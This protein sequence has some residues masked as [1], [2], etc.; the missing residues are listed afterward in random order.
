MTAGKIFCS[1]RQKIVDKRA[2]GC[3]QPLASSVVSAT[4]VGLAQTGFTTFH[5][6]S[7]HNKV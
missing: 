5:V 1:L 3:L 7:L 4:A 2:F 6:T